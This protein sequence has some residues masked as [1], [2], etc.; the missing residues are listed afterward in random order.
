[1]TLNKN[2]ETHTSSKTDKNFRIPFQ[3]PQNEPAFDIRDY[4]DFNRKFINVR[5]QIPPIIEKINNN[6][7]N[8]GFLKNKYKIVLDAYGV[9]ATTLNI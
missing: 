8:D 3:E 6:S 1:M 9:N 2:G 4:I 5:D 7:I